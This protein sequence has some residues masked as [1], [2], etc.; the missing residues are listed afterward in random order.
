MRPTSWEIGPALKMAERAE[1]KRTI[2]ATWGPP[3]SEA[4]V[5]A[6]ALDSL[7]D[8]LHDDAAVRDSLT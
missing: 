7:L 8:R 6:D 5:D 4:N 3:D 1:V 2:T